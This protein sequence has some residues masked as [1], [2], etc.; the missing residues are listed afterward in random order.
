MMNI[1]KVPFFSTNN[2]NNYN[3]D[4]VKLRQFIKVTSNPRKMGNQK[5]KI[6]Y[7]VLF[8]H[9]K[10]NYKQLP[11]FDVYDEKK[12]ALTYTGQKPVLC[13]PP[14]RNFSR[15]RFFSKGDDFENVYPF[16]CL[17]LVRTYGGIIEHPYDSL[18]W[19]LFDCPKVGS[20]DNYGGTSF[21][22][23][24]FDFGYYTRKRTRLY[25]VGLKCLKDIPRLNLRFEIVSRKFQNLTVKQRSET[26]PQLAEWFLEILKKIES[27]T[28]SQFIK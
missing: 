27:N 21:V 20:F 4:L 10:S 26:T 28:Q 16:F 19:K 23:D 13:H 15:L 17:K 11:S 24:Q 6:K 25:I 14:C 8:C 2:Y 9:S 22:F 5:T 18:F 7:P 1:K 12:D 3:I